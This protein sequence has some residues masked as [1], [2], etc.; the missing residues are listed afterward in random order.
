M[1]HETGGVGVGGWKGP[2]KVHDN[3]DN[4]RRG[5]GR[6]GIEKKSDVPSQ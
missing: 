2:R 6:D 1:G 5:L 3:R 4:G